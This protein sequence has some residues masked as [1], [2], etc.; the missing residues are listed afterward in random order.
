MPDY[1]YHYTDIDTL[2]LILKSKKIR[3]NRLDRVDDISEGSSFEKL[4]LQEFF[5]VSCWTYDE[6]ESIPQWH[7]YTNEMSGVRMKLPKKLF[8]SEKIEVPDSHKAFMYGDIYSPIPFNQIFSNEYFILPS[9]LN[10]NEFGSKV[11]YHEN[12]EQMKN[13]AINV[14]LSEGRFKIKKP[15]KLASLKSPVWAF[16]K[17]YRFV[18]MILPSFPNQG[19]I[20]ENWQKNFPNFVANALNEGKGANLNYFDIEIETKA[21]ESVEITLGPLCPPGKK[22]IVESLIEKYTSNGKVIDS[23]LKGTLRSPKR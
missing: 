14:N 13:E 16:Q 20:D 3:F 5:F 19:F 10:E 8:K 12:F 4:N 21:L 2:A 22:I 6:I 18:L 17:E 1:I 7:M 15:N 9:F 23:N 11:E